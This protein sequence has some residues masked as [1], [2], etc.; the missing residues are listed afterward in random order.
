MTT[1]VTG[2]S[3]QLGRHIIS[4]LLDRGVAPG[5][6]IATARDLAAIA[7]LA[8]QGVQTR[9]ADYDDHA[10][11]DKALAGVDRAVLVS[12][13]ALGSRVDQHR[14]VIEAA[15]RQGV[16]LLA[17][18]SILRADT[19]TL[20]LATD[21]QATEQILRDSGVPFALLR[22]GWYLENYTAGIG[23]ALDAGQVYG[24]AGDGRVS[25]AARRDYAEAAA[26]VLA[27]G[28]HAGA[29]YELAGDESFSMPEY[30]AALSSA[31]G[32]DI[33]YT[34]LPVE[35]YAAALQSAGLPA[36]LADVLASSDAGVARGELADDRR[37]LSQ[38]IGRPT[39]PLTDAL[40]AALA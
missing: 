29:V 33:G 2:T 28:D 21:H 19:A 30:A 25:A 40:Q 39:A 27:G 14:N 3:G 38:L 11:L 20:D 36:P 17:Y 31:S 12:S 15:A 32:R 37:Q 35:D 23:A 9:H 18:T 24:A 22:N 16:G 13:N 34:D 4:A 5:E 6:I 7:D 1:L 8:E 10:T 26:E